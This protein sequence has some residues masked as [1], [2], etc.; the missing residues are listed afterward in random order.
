VER[1]AAQDPVGLWLTHFL[2]RKQA[3]QPTKTSLGE[4]TLAWQAAWNRGAHLQG[5]HL[6]KF[7]SYVRIASSTQSIGFFFVGED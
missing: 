2:I 6:S 5:F 3:A 1:S 4:G 7:S